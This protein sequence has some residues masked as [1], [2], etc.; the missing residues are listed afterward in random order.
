MYVHLLS[1]F[2]TGRQM[3]STLHLAACWARSDWH[4][5]C[6]MVPIRINKIICKEHEKDLYIH[7]CAYFTFLY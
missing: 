6:H 3:P 5:K 1:L 4:C 7:A 2:I